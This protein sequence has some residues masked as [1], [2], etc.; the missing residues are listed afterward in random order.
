MKAKKKVTAKRPAAKKKTSTPKG[1]LTINGYSIQW[2]SKW[3]GWQVKKKG[4]LVH[5]SRK[6]EDARTFAL[7]R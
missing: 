7:N 2:S 6:K 3:N 5:M 4:R 1:S